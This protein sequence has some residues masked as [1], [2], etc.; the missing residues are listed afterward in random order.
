MP[1]SRRGSGTARPRSGT[2]YE[3]RVRDSLRDLV[4]EARTLLQPDE[5]ALALVRRLGRAL[6]LAHCAFV[7]SR[8]ARTKGA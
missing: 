7:W 8:R 6:D 1:G 5:V 2:P 3:A 4:E